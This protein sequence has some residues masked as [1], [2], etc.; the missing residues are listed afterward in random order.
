[1]GGEQ[2]ALTV[3]EEGAVTGS[4]PESRT[5]AAWPL[6][7]VS[8]TQLHYEGH[9]SAHAERSV[10]YIAPCTLNFER[11]F[12]KRS[13]IH[14]GKQDPGKMTYEKWIDE[15]SGRSGTRVC[16]YMCAH[17][18]SGNCH[19]CLHVSEGLLKRH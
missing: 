11:T 17:R 13:G 16:L 7:R 1:M 9:C 6:S 5:H 2:A 15:T 19:T 8:G 14:K 4:T 3:R 18:T 10:L 12:H